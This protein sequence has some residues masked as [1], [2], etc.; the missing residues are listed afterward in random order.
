MVEEATPDESA[1]AAVKRAEAT[2]AI[3]ERTGIEGAS[4]RASWNAAAAEELQAATE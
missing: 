2:A 1:A 4:K 3:A